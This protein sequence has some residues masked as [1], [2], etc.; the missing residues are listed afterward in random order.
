MIDVFLGFIL[1]V[2]GYWAH[3]QK[4]LESGRKCVVN[5]YDSKI[6]SKRIAP[7]FFLAWGKNFEDGEGEYS[8]AIIELED[9]SVITAEPEE[10]KFE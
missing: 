10:V 6:K 9:G 5:F 1:F 2:F 7:G 8:I 4:P 3:S